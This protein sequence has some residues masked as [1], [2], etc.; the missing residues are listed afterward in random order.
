MH[1]I[2]KPSAV[3]LEPAS[4]ARRDVTD[5]LHSVASHGHNHEVI[6]VQS[7]GIYV[8]AFGEVF[9]ACR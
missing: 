1:S 7:V 4:D 9:H 2:P 8:Q 6:G 5:A 3:A